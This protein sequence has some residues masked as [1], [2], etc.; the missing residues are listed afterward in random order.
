MNSK[1]RVIKSRMRIA[2]AQRNE[3][4]RRLG[5]RNVADLNLSLCGPSDRGFDTSKANINTAFDIYF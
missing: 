1:F 4:V 3:I 5:V 2:M